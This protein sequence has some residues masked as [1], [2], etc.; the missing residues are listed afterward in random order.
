MVDSK[1]KENPHWLRS[2]DC[3]LNLLQQS[4]MQAFNIDIRQNTFES[5]KIQFMV[6][7]VNYT[8]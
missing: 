8:C 6:D 2:K 3:N 7:D 5:K 1:L 4:I